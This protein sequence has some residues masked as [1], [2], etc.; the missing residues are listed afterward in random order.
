MESYIVR[1]YRR[2]EVSPQNITGTVE[3]VGV[4]GMKPFHSII[5]LTSILREGG[6][7]PGKV[8]K[9]RLS[10]RKEDRT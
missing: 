10:R 4:E 9:M 5:E 8:K 6:S 3:E 2:G 1:I 7:E